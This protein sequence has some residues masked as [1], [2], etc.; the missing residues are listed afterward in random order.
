M[1]DVVYEILSSRLNHESQQK[2]F[3]PDFHNLLNRKLKPTCLKAGV[4]VLVFHELRHTFASHLAML[5]VPLIKIKE[6]LGHRDIK[7]TMVYA[8]I[9]D[10]SLVGITDC[11]TGGDKH[12][13]REVTV[14]RKAPI[15]SLVPLLC[16]LEAKA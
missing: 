6:L 3:T 11:L 8:H 7:S 9:D 14:P 10:K 2:V 16:P 15:F 4:S 12:E 13:E 1:N 5:G